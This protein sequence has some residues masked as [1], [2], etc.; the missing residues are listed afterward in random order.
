MNNAISIKK[1]YVNYGGTPAIEDV[2]L[3][4]MKGEFVGIMGPNG[5][6]KS[7]LLKAILGLV[8]VSSGEISI[9]EQSVRKGR[10]K[11]GYVPQHSAVDRG[12]PISVCEAVMMGLVHGGLHPLFRY[13]DKQRQTAMEK[14]KKVGID[15]L[16]QRQISE[17]SGGEFQRMLIARALAT[18]P[19]ILLL[20]EPT[21]SVDPGSREHIYELLGELNENMTVVLVTHDLFAVSSKVQRIVCVNRG[22]VYHGVPEL[23]QEVVDHLYGCPVELVAHGVPHRVLKEH[24]EGEH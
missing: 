17:L 9:L 7:T 2:N 13:S 19:E 18:Q 15:D 22:V 23:T 20:D 5:G 24:G 10:T 6:G 16:A 3:E 1:L 4:I 21:A 11:I 14:L 8:P 12:F